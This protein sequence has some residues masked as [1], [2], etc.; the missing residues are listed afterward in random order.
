MRN[1]MDLREMEQN[2]RVESVKASKSRKHRRISGRRKM[3]R[4]LSR[5]LTALVVLLM[6]FTFSFCVHIF[7]GQDFSA[8]DAKEKMYTSVLVYPGDSIDSLAEEYLSVEYE[9]RESLKR[10]IVSINH[11]D[12]DGSLTSGNHII[13]PVYR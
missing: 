7:A 2:T 9:D 5:F 4:M 8:T 1:M 12:Y 6:V 13:I 3:K 11:L 10:E